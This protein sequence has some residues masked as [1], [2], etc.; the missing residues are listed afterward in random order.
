MLY[1]IVKACVSGLLIAVV[2]EISKRSPAVGA[3][4][5]SLPL[6][7]ILGFIWLWKDT[8]DT[9][10]IASLA[11]GTF[12]Y[13][14]PTLPMFLLFPVLLRHGIGFWMG[15]TTSCALT[16]ALYF[17]TAQ[18]LGRFG[19]N[20]RRDT[21]LPIIPAVRRKPFDDPAWLFDL[22]EPNNK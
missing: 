12:W 10:R 17:V 8:G 1:L 9:L 6:I 22:G 14:L 5:L 19:I 4:V 11:E 20:L 13:I 15:L 16:I 21:P 3:I 18:V 7:S 2:S